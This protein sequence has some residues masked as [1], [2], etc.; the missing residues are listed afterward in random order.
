MILNLK[1]T[2]IFLIAAI[3]YISIGYLTTF[4]E[5][6]PL[7]INFHDSY[8]VI[9]H[10]HEFIGFG[11]L[12]LVLSGI[13]WLLQKAKDK[14]ITNLGMAHSWL[15]VIGISLFLIL[16]LSFANDPEIQESESVVPL[17][18]AYIILVGQLIFVMQIM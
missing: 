2:T 3:G 7:D 8:L 5:M 13:Q 4:Y 9:E 6:P 1:A 14:V 10:G 11:I 17:V 15:T 18:L 12:F 16:I